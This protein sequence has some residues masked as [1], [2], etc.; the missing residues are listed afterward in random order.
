MNSDN[1][2]ILSKV[3]T[4]QDVKN[5]LESDQLGEL[6]H[7]YESLRIHGEDWSKT[8]WGPVFGKINS[9]TLQATTRSLDCSVAAIVAAK[10]I[11]QNAIQDELKLRL[12]QN[13]KGHPDA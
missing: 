8:N 11:I 5:M 3:K 7:A 12:N 9:T 10:E 6:R 13:G 4:N 1:D 2:A